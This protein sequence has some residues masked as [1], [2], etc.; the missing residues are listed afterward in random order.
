MNWTKL[1]KGVLAAAL[2]GA[3]TG[4]T[5]ALTNPDNVS[6]GRVA[7]AAGAGAL[8]AILAYFKNPPRTKKEVVE[9]L[10][11]KVKGETEDGTK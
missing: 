9:E 6:L 10:L 11:D 5:D 3:A 4:A 7:I 8:V 2:G 1:L